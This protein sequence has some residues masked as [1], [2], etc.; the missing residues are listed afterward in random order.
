MAEHIID[1]PMFSGNDIPIWATKDDER[2]RI[3]IEFEYLSTKT[4]A[5]ILKKVTDLYETIFEVIYGEPPST[6]D[7]LV[8]EYARTGNSIDTI[9]DTLAKLITSKRGRIVFAVVVALVGGK[10]LYD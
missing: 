2:L 10:I 7:I 8:V 5:E 1:P 4:F 3:H 9:L 6:Y